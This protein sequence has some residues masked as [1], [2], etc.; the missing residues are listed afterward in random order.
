MGR[1]P[2]WPGG[3]SIHQPLNL[4]QH[5]K[6]AH[7]NA[8]EPRRASAHAQVFMMHRRL[9]PLKVSETPADPKTDEEVCLCRVHKQGKGSNGCPPGMPRWHWK[10]QASCVPN[11]D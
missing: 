9:P 10:P 4:L 1:P 6:R 5:V 2:P 11:R 8:T 3:F 7:Q